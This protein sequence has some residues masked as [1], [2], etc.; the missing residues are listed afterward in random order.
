MRKIDNTQQRIFG[1]TMGARVTERPV[2]SSRSAETNLDKM[3]QVFGRALNVI[4]DGVK[5]NI[6]EAKREEEETRRANKEAELLRRRNASNQA[7]A[8]LVELNNYL[9]EMDA[10]F[11]QGNAAG[12]ADRTFAEYERK[13][14]AAVAR[15]KG[16]DPGTA[17]AFQNRAKDIGGRYKETFTRRE[18]AMA[19]KTAI[20]Q[21]DILMKQSLDDYATNGN[22]A[23]L[24]NALDRFYEKYFAVSGE[25]YTPQEKLKLFVAA[26]AKGELF[27][28]GKSYVLVDDE[29]ASAKEKY[30]GR[31]IIYRSQAEEMRSKLEEEAKAFTSQREALIN[32]AHAKLLDR[33]LKRGEIE[34]ALDYYAKVQSEFPEDLRMSGA[35]REQIEA[36]IQRRAITQEMT[37]GIAAVIGNIMKDYG[38]QSPRVEQAAVR[39]ALAD[40]VSSLP[41]GQRKEADA[42]ARIAYARY[43]H[44]SATNNAAKAQNF[45]EEYEKQPDAD[46]KYIF[47][48]DV[49]NDDNADRV[50]RALAQGELDR[51]HKE[52][53]D[54]EKQEAAKQKREQDVKRA[55]QVNK[56]RVAFSGGSKL[57]VDIE[58]GYLAE[59]DLTKMDKVGLERVMLA[60]QLDN[61]TKNEV[62]K[63]LDKRDTLLK[64]DEVYGAVEQLLGISRGEATKIFPSLVGYV[65]GM[66]GTLV[67]ESEKQRRDWVEATIRNILETDVVRVGKWT[68]T[69]YESIPKAIEAR[70]GSLDGLNMSVAEWE[71]LYERQDATNKAY[72]GGR[73][74]NRGTVQMGTNWLGLPG[75]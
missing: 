62:R 36:L 49:V 20:E 35:V 10:K 60:M 13:V 6:A 70:D 67:F 7:D 5:R 33:Y 56:F 11:P 66:R 34:A 41:E 68:N 15:L 74:P 75:R 73:A 39:D 69:V 9:R 61:E 57:V 65:E 55:V 12:Y 14:N 25:D 30:R 32:S 19:R 47:L 51:V 54:L 28:R 50:Y 72:G 2:F 48:L 31:N 71:K 18:T 26:M 8:E 53:A 3:A 64:K 27:F 22:A 43:N 40:Y 37:T 21:Q 52:A 38:Q 16:I 1:R 29:D 23:S 4:D 17:A 24:Q 45:F 46:S 58:G 63:L 59:Y 42:L 44:E